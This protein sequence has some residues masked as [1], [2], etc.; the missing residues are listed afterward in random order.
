MQRTA[1]LNG[2]V[3]EPPPPAPILSSTH[4]LLE[5]REVLVIERG[6]IRAQL[7]K[8]TMFSQFGRAVEL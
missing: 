3:K 5:E 4:H 2:A 6:K 8:N 1:G 7:Q